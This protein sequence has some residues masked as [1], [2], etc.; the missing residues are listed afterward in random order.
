MD[1]LAQC[2]YNVIMWDIKSLRWHTDFPVAQHYKVMSAHYLQ[3]SVQPDKTSDVA[4]I[5]NSKL[6]TVGKWIA[7]QLNVIAMTMIR[8]PVPRVTYPTL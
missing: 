7:A 2:Q 8:T 4:R 3:A 1:W 5:E 6:Y